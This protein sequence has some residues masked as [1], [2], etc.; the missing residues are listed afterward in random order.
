MTSAQIPQ[1]IYPPG[2]G[3]QDR[4]LTDARPAAPSVTLF[5]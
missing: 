2:T 4:L 3:R 1:L 5:G